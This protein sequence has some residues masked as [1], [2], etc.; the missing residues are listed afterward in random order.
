M[1]AGI[2]RQQGAQRAGS[3]GREPQYAAGESDI[4][5][6]QFFRVRHRSGEPL[7]VHQIVVRRDFARRRDSG[8]AARRQGCQREIHEERLGEQL[9]GNGRQFRCRVAGAVTQPLGKSRY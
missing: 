1:V 7:E 3:S 5:K 2:A 6:G 4:V 9:V 8:S